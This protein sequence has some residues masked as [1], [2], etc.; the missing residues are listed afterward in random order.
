MYPAK[1][2]ERPKVPFAAGY[3]PVQPGELPPST[4]RQIRHRHPVTE[5]ARRLCTLLA[6]IDFRQLA[7]PTALFFLW[8]PRPSHGP[9]TAT[10]QDGERA[11][12]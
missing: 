11:H 5:S 6:S 10:Q 2:Q 12:Y 4:V 1:I 9:A 8:P 3:Q 7:G